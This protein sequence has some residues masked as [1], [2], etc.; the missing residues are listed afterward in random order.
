MK[1]Y[2]FGFILLCASLVI[3]IPA[4]QPS[5]LTHD[6]TINYSLIPT[7]NNSM[8]LQGYTPITLYD[9]FKVSYDNE[10]LALSQSNWADD[11]N[12]WLNWDGDSLEFNESKLATI[13]YDATSAQ[14]VAGTIAGTLDLTQH[15]DGDYD[16]QTLNITEV[17]GSPGLDLRVN[18]TDGI[19]N[20]NAGVMRYYTSSLS[21]DSP[22]IQLWDYEGEHW[23]DYPSITETGSYLIIEQ[24]VFDSLEHVQDGKVQMRIY[25]ASN[26]NTQNKYYIDWL[27][28]AKGFGT[29]A[30][31]EADPYSIHKDGSTSWEG[32]EPGNGYNST[33]WDVV[34]AN[35]L[36]IGIGSICNNG[37]DMWIVLNKTSAI[38]DGEYCI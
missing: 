3:A 24:S 19:D 30:G 36:E 18:F 11:S 35:E 25:K 10:Y 23:E 17:S 28:I 5:V 16:G 9:L 22:I 14:V 12:G 29:P 20:F 27:T 38:A 8:F 7:V 31:E 37:T 26:G 34:E 4:D 15:S 13:Y 33:G 6:E 2:L 32:N 21:G 1:L